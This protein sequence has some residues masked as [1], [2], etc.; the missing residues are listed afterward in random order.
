MM[1]FTGKLAH[2]LFNANFKVHHPSRSAKSSET[3]EE[4]ETNKERAEDILERQ[5]QLHDITRSVIPRAVTHRVY[6]NVREVEI[7]RL[8]RFR[9][10]G[11]ALLNAITPGPNDD[12]PPDDVDPT[13]KSPNNVVNEFG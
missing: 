4:R 8:G 1:P 3:W 7:A 9:I 5:D 10:G 12:R 2:K 6:G 11:F 13:C